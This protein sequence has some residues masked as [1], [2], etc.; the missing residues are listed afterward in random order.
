MAV[1]AVMAKLLKFHIR[2]VALG[3]YRQPTMR[4]SQLHSRRPLDLSPI[5]RLCYL[6]GV[7]GLPSRIYA[8]YLFAMQLGAPGMTPTYRKCNKACMLPL[9]KDRLLWLPGPREGR[10]RG[11]PLL[12]MP[13]PDQASR[14]N[15]APK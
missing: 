12:R 5:L 14:A 1:P 8:L 7:L 2:S 3:L 9:R 11:L 4:P 6:R 10:T 15:F 13:A